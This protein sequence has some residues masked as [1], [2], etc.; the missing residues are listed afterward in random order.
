[1]ELKNIILHQVLKEINGNAKLNN[2]NHLLQINEITIGFVEELVNKYTSKNPTSGTFEDDSDTY[3]FQKRISD[4]L[5][6][7]LDFIEFSKK[8]MDL[9]KKEIDIP[10]TT[11]GYVVFIHYIESNRDFIITAM[12]EKSTKYTVEDSNLDIHKLQILDTDK[13]ARAN[14]V[15]IDKWENKEDSYLTFIKETREVSKYFQKFIGS[16]DLTSAKANVGAVYDVFKLYCREQNVPTERKDEIREN[17]TDYFNSQVSKDEDVNL[18]AI[19]AIINK[20]NPQFFIDL[21]QSNNI[22]ISGSFRLTKKQDYDKFT[23]NTVKE[24]GY[25]LTFDKSLIRDKKIVRNGTDIVIKNVPE[26][27]I[28]EIFEDN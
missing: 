20:E 17:L 28:N 11:G 3:P 24:T 4:Y 14:R 7:K 1:M 9:L 13:I 5:G 23:R 12:L 15:N 19:S 26:K 8:A 27:Q 21:A 2:S 10:Q 16:T 18:L 22:E 6:N 25:K